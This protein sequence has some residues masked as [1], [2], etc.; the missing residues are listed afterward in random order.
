MC[1]GLKFGVYL[2]GDTDLILIEARNDD[3]FEART[4][5]CTGLICG[6]ELIGA[7]GYRGEDISRPDIVART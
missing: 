3:L 1:Y 7:R 2:F 5:L 6:V 4:L